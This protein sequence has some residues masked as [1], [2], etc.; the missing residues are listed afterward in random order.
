M[1]Y[2]AENVFDGI[3]VGEDEGHLLEAYLNAHDY[4]PGSRRGYILDL[5]K[6][7]KWFTKANGERFVVGR[8]TTRDIADFKNHLRRDRGQAVPTVNRNLTTIRQ[9]LRLAG[10][11]WPCRRQSRQAGQGTETDGV[12]PKRIGPDPSAEVAA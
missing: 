4:A 2:S 10:R 9:V 1:K 7:A 3:P 8:V 12:G 6:F 11:T 5:R